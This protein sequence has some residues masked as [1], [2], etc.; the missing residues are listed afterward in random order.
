MMWAITLALA[1]SPGYEV[2]GDSI[3]EPLAGAVGDPARGREIVTS[4]Q[5]GLCLLCHSGPFP[6]ERFPGDLAPSLAGVGARLSEGR[7][8]LRI[9][10]P[11]SLDPDTIMPS[12]YRADG[13][14]RV[15]EAW[16]GRPILSAGQIEDVVA[17]LATLKD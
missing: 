13:L 4:R 17:F 16:R 3:P 5:T 10:D 14:D 11:G 12:Y 8:R 2:V 1:L 6:E 9:V 15:A 7:I